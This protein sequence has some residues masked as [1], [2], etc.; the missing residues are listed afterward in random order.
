LH[1]LS[2]L[3][4][5]IEKSIYS[6]RFIAICAIAKAINGND[7]HSVGTFRPMAYKKNAT[8]K[9]KANQLKNLAAI[10]CSFRVSISIY[11]CEWV[12]KD[13]SNYMFWM[14]AS[15][16]PQRPVVTPQMGAVG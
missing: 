16:T 6:L 1:Q 4:K 14:D 8:V 5:R 9:I 15:T 3:S 13:E 2:H 7:S 12:A 10:M 11:T